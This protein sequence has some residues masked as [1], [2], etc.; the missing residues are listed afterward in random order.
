MRADR[1]LTMLLILQNRGR[2]TAQ[3]LAEEL[4]VSVR[5]IYRDIDALSFAGVP[6]YT[7]RGPGG[8]I[9]LM[10]SYRTNLTGLTENEMRSLFL[11]SIPTPLAE[12]GLSQQVKGALLKL[13]AALPAVYNQDE[14]GVQQRLHLDWA[15]WHRSEERV[16]HLRALQEAT[17][18]NQRVV[19]K[20]RSMVRNQVVERTI[21]PYSLVAKAGTWYLV[22]VNAGQKRVYRVSRIVEV[23]Q[24]AGKFERPASYNLVKFWQNWCQ[25][26]EERRTY[27]RVLARIK[28]QLIPYLIFIL[29]DQVQ[30]NINNAQPPDDD[31][32][33]TIELVFES[34]EVARNHAL[35]CGR[36]IEILEPQA[37]RVSVI[38]YAEQIISFYARAP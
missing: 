28:P 6:L 31:G 16:P 13:R 20:L 15:G 24:L 2:T 26:Y 30:E 1:L 10:D 9:S 33:L 25:R 7:D 27:F 21:A 8:G 22:G 5:T 35:S 23:T 14:D 12:L 37:L 17:W 4:E 11:L 29:G 18:H 32:W 38:D 19:I 34:F 3:T 36:S